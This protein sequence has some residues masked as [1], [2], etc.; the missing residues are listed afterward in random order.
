MREST[1]WLF[2]LLAGAVLLTVLG[3]HYGV[4]HLSTLFG[5]DHATVLSFSSVSGRSGMLFYLAV[6]LV[7]LPA[8]LYH[9]LYGLR[10]LIFEL[11][12][13]GPVLR[14]WISRILVLS[15]FGFFIFGAY[16]IITGFLG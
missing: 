6:Y 2:H 1:L 16:T 11:S 13:I 9:G 15:G 8:G 3:I 10:S 5:I 12:F 7:L 4:M 14:Q